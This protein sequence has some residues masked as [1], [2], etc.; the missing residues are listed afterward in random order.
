MDISLRKLYIKTPIGVLVAT[1][2]TASSPI[3]DGKRIWV[4]ANFKPEDQIHGKFRRMAKRNGKVKFTIRAVASIKGDDFRLDEGTIEMWPVGPHLKFKYK[5]PVK[6]I[7]R[8]LANS[9]VSHYDLFMYQTR[10]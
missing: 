2:K 5:M 6:T 3:V 4:V 10:S 1:V 8:L 9:T 7:K